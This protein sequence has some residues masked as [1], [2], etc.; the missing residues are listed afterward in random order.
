MIAGD[1]VKIESLLLLSHSLLG[2]ICDF[3]PVCFDDQAHVNH[4]YCRDTDSKSDPEA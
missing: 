1:F 2:Q 3:L 4:C